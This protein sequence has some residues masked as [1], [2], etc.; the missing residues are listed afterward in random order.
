MLRV[1]DLTFLTEGDKGIISSCLRQEERYF[2]C[3]FLFIL[4]FSFYSFLLIILHIILLRIIIILIIIL[5]IVLHILLHIHNITILHIL[6][7][8]LII[9]IRS[10]ERAC[11]S[12]MSGKIEYNLRPARIDRGRN[13]REIP[14][15]GSSSGDQCLERSGVSVNTYLLPVSRILM[16]FFFVMNLFF[17][18]L[19]SVMKQESF[20]LLLF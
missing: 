12:R 9:L 16:Y 2:Y 19:P 5:R 4:F 13:S 8:I 20:L 15:R 3:P 1:S 14:D 18:V 10:C 11:Y 7:L 17:C 6:L